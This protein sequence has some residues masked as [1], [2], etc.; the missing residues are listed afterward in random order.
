MLTAYLLLALSITCEMVAASVVVQS[1][2]WTVLKPTIICIVGYAFSYYL[3]GMCLSD[4]DLGVG[5]ATWGAV[6]TIV[7][8]IVG[9]FIYKQKLTKWGVFA[10]ML[11]IISTL[12]LNLFGW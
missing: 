5:Y 1:K 8:P 2:G 12:T 10:L 3:F 4:I 11:I 9:Y 7:T 6:G